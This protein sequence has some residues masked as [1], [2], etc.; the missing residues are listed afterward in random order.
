MSPFGGLTDNKESSG[1]CLCEALSDPVVNHSGQT[2]LPNVKGRFLTEHT[3][4]H[5]HTHTAYDT[6]VGCCKPYLSFKMYKSHITFDGADILY[7]YNIY[8]KTIM[9]IMMDVGC[10]FRHRGQV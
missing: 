8:I 9:I 4:T 7:T 6:Y 3:H 2:A 10:R 5:T 1:S